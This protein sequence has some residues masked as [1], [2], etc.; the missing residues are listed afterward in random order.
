MER[1]R[2]HRTFSPLAGF[3]SWSLVAVL[4]GA[5][6]WAPASGCKDDEE[7]TAEDGEGSSGGEDTG[8]EGM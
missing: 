5:V 7:T 4:L 1:I 2:T 6:A 3:R 8:G